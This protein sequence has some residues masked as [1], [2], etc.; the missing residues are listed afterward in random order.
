[1]NMSIEIDQSILDAV[2]VFETA[3]RDPELKNHKA[4]ND[5][6]TTLL[7]KLLSRIKIEQMIKAAMDRMEEDV[8]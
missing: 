7:A 1:M 3:L 4:F 5:A 8:N 2:E 6:K